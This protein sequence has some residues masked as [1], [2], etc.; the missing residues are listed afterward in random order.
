VEEGD[1][2]ELISRNQ[3]GITISEMNRLFVQ[4][5]YNRDLLKK[6]IGTADLP[7]SWREYFLPRLKTPATNT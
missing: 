4:E 7:E 6:A 1:S 3:S 2:I 5:R